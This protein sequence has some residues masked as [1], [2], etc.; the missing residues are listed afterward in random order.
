M[1]ETNGNIKMKTFQ[2][3]AGIIITVLMVIFGFVFNEISSVDAKYNECQVG[4]ANIQSQLSS[5]NTNIEW[6]KEKLK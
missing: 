5:L 3:I 4:I 1:A 2:W 6:I